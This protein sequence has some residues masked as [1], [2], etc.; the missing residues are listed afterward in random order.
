MPKHLV[1]SALL[2]LSVILAFGSIYAKANLIQLP[3]I[4]DYC[5]EQNLP[6]FESC[7]RYMT[8]NQDLQVCRSTCDAKVRNCVIRIVVRD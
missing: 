6:C 2:T 7:T 1:K 8:T 5:Q 3:Y 4:I